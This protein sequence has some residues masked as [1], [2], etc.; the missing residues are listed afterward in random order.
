MP[1]EK[2]R[3]LPVSAIRSRS[4][5][6]EI[7]PEATFQA[8]T[9]TRSSRSTA[10]GL[11][12]DERKSRSRCSVCSREADPL[13]LGELHAPPVLESRVVLGAEADPPGLARRGLRR[14]DVRL[15]L[16]RVGA[17]VRDRVDVGVRRAEAAVVRLRH[18]GDHQGA[19]SAVV[20]P[21]SH[22]VSPV[23]PGQHSTGARV[24]VDTS[25]ARLRQ[26]AMLA[27]FP[28][29]ARTGTHD[30]TSLESGRARIPAIVGDGDA[31]PLRP[32]RPPPADAAGRGPRPRPPCARRGPVLLGLHPRAQTTAGPRCS[33]GSAPA[34]R[35]PVP[36][37]RG[38]VP[39]A[40]AA[41]PGDLRGRAELDATARRLP[42][43]GGLGRLGPHR[44]KWDLAGEVRGPTRVPP[45]EEP[46]QHGSLAL[47]AE[48]L[49]AGPVPGDHALAVRLGRGILRRKG[50][51][52]TRRRRPR[53]TTPGA[54]GRCSTTSATSSMSCSCATR[55]SART[56]TGR[57]AGWATSSG[58][59]RASGSR[60]RGLRGPQRVRRADAHHEHE[61]RERRAAAPG[62][63]GHDRPGHGRRAGAARLSG[64]AG[65]ERPFD[66]RVREAEAL[67]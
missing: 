26:P 30:P 41:Q 45:G 1:L 31:A 50:R 14:R 37:A 3:G 48:A 49:P 38:A 65:R 4:G 34:P 53:S 67:P 20:E 2:S 32:A 46:A 35:R 66:G 54:S 16:H 19:R 22:G 13:G 23:R 15:E 36:A 5:W 51:D 40:G 52:R 62:R 60:G 47:A 57:C 42:H 28:G 43:D 61:R 18:L 56:S 63:A 39:D 17:G 7:S 44:V 55:T 58:L 25:P 10:S 29:G 24:L 12:G 11:K 33:S 8:G 59:R 64:P 6:L 9:S 21:A 27:P